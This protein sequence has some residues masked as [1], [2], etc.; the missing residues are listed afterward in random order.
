MANQTDLERVTPTLNAYAPKEVRF[1]DMPVDQ[2]LKEA[3]IM[4]VAATEDAAKFAEVGF[5]VEKIDELSL[6]IDILRLTQAQLT[7][8]IGEVKDAMAEWAEK[9]PAAFELRAAILAAAAYALRNVP[10]AARAIKKIRAGHS[11]ADK[12]CDLKAL[13]ELGWKYQPHLEAINFNFA[14]L[15]TATKKSDELSNLYAKA[16]VEKSTK[17]A[18]DLRDRAFTHMRK[19][20]GEV[21]DVAEYVFRKDRERM[22]FY[23]S[24]YRSRRRL[25]SKTE[26]VQEEVA[27]PAMDK[28]A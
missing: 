13:A 15:E 3:E 22:D 10:D 2:A 27:E 12:L 14:M 1:P 25:S 7:A 24:S 16:F 9:A 8:A 19:L 18:K 28:A 17:D 4:A 20:M 23:Y 6:A 11:D 5:E 26:T 21:L